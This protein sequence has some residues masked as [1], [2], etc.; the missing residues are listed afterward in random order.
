ML[1]WQ[2][3]CGVCHP[4]VL[5][6]LRGC[7]NLEHS[8]TYSKIWAYQAIT[9]SC[10]APCSSLGKCQISGP[11][12]YSEYWAAP[13]CDSSGASSLQSAKLFFPPLL[14]ISSFI[15]EYLMWK[16]VGESV[17]K[18]QDF[19]SLCTWRGHFRALRAGKCISLPKNFHSHCLQWSQEIINSIYSSFH[20]LM[21]MEITSC[22][23]IGHTCF[24]LLLWYP[25]CESWLYCQEHRLISAPCSNSRLR[26][27]R[28]APNR[29][30]LTTFWG[31]LFIKQ[32]VQLKRAYFYAE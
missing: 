4:I 5:I 18:Q 8:R 22:T 13:G 31:C 28:V 10:C 2:Y 21:S 12:Y 17:G 23:E 25:G 24:L 3:S 16:T 27:L 7:C 1:K 11:L 14:P 19:P 29:D 20:Y 30:A 32:W 15:R 6:S 26:K 9:G